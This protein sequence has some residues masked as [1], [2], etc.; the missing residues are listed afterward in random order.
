MPGNN[1]FIIVILLLP[2]N[3]KVSLVLCTAYNI[4]IYMYQGWGNIR[5]FRIP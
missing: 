3:N 5:I 4:Y 1:E 2:Y